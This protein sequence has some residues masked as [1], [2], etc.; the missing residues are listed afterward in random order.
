LLASDWGSKI[1]SALKTWVSSLWEEFFALSSQKIHNLS[2]THQ[3]LQARC[4]D[5]KVWLL[6]LARG[7]CQMERLRF[8]A[9]NPVF[10]LSVL[11]PK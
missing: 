7:N 9:L 3:V 4:P 11:K 10:L 8:E 5:V 1:T 6:N 2:E